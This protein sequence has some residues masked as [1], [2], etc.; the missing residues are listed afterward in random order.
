[1]LEGGGMVIEV[2]DQGPGVPPHLRERIFE[3]FTRGDDDSQPGMGLGLPL[4]R[5][6]A[7]GLGAHVEVDDNPSGIGSVFRLSFP[8]DAAPALGRD[9]RPGQVTKRE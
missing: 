1:V 3:R 9:G 6:L 4:V 2:V 8:P 7:S 5:M